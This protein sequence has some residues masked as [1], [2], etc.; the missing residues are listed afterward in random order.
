MV[1]SKTYMVKN[2]SKSI[3]IRS[4]QTSKWI[5]TKPT[6][7]IMDMVKDLQLYVDSLRILGK[8]LVIQRNAD[9]SF[10]F[11][12]VAFG[13]RNFISPK[14]Q[15]FL[16]SLAETGIQAR[17]NYLEEANKK[18]KFIKK[19]G[20][21]IYSRF[22]LKLNSNFKGVT[23]FREIFTENEDEEAAGSLWYVLALC[24]VVV[25]L[26]TVIFIWELGYAKVQKGKKER[27]NSIVGRVQTSN[28]WMRDNGLI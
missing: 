23:G 12:G 11:N 24:S 20:K 3:K 17:F 5:S 27:I 16:R 2:I 14:I 6:F 7:S 9:V 15:A 18:L 26:A 4:S 13:R 1:E 22:I 8:R 28:I 19:L 25:T 10:C 21:E